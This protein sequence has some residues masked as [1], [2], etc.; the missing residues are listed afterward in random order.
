[1]GYESLGLGFPILYPK[2]MRKMMLQLS[3]FGFY[4]KPYTLD[5]AT[6][7]PEPCNPTMLQLSGF[8][9]RGVCGCRALGI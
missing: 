3:G 9:Y 1:M 7:N 8:Y 5:P 6:M 4:Y 2:G